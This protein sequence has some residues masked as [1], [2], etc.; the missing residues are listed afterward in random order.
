[1]RIEMPLV[2]QP[3]IESPKSIEKKELTADNLNGS[4][5]PEGS[6]PFFPSPLGFSGTYSLSSLRAAVDYHAKYLTVAESNVQAAKHAPM[7]P[8]AILDYFKSR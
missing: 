5:E 7:I 1:M 8:Q 2:P 6:Q 3:L 4:N